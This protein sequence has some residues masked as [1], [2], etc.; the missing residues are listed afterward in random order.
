MRRIL[1]LA[2]LFVAAT[3]QSPVQ[4][5]RDPWVFRSVLDERARMVTVAL[6][7]DMWIAYDASDCGLYKAWKGGVHFDGAVYTTVHG[8][9]PTSEGTAY[10]TG[11][12]G[13]LWSATASDGKTT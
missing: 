8:P 2:F 7:N 11:R 6:S 12:G 1:A 4:R 3:P 13:K 9:Q 10:V 5:P